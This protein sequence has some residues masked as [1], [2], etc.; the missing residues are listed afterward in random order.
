VGGGGGGGGEWNDFR[1][2]VT[3]ASLVFSQRCDFPG[4][5]TGSLGNPFPTFRRGTMLLFSTVQTSENSGV[6]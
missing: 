1:T 4:H 3:F 6:L 2:G 5:D